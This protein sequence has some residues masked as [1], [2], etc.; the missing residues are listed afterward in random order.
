M[1]IER[2]SIVLQLLSCR[3]GWTILHALTLSSNGL[4]WTDRCIYVSIYLQ[5]FLEETQ[6][7]QGGN[8]R[9]EW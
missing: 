4:H 7:Y 3:V 9:Y 1:A 8:L 5:D 6:E 2:R